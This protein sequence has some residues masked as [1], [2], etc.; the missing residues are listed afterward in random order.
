MCQ[1][2][3]RLCDLPRL[4]Q[5]DCFFRIVPMRENQAGKMNQA[6]NKPLIDPLTIE[7]AYH[8]QGLRG[9]RLGLFGVA[10]IGE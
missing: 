5:K 10:I 7:S 8:G 1:A 9:P 2:D 4:V 3:D 6:L